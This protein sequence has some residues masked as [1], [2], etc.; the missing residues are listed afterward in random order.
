MLTETDDDKLPECTSSTLK[1]QQIK[2]WKTIADDDKENCGS[3]MMNEGV[4]CTKEKVNA[5]VE[6]ELSA[7]EIKMMRLLEKNKKMSTIYKQIAL[8]MGM[9]AP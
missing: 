4:A 7:T 3:L 2:N 6:R 9:Q 1:S 8:N 5:K